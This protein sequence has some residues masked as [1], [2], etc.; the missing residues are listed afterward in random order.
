VVVV[1]ATKYLYEKGSSE[2]PPTANIEHEENARHHVLVVAPIILRIL[3][4]FGESDFRFLHSISL[5]LS[6]RGR[7]LKEVGASCPRFENSSAREG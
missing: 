2:S 4:A 5:V 1:I 7:D 3:D 6:A